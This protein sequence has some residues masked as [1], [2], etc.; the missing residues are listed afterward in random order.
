MPLKNLI[1]IPQE[2]RYSKNLNLTT[3][4]SIESPDLFRIPS[5]PCIDRGPDRLQPPVTY[6]HWK[7]G[8]DTGGYKTGDSKL[9]PLK[10]TANFARPTSV[11]ADTPMF[12]KVL[13]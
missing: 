8:E 3:A 7:D 13:L 4:V 5:V 6:K 9:E 11:S 1:D 2:N 10:K 12:F